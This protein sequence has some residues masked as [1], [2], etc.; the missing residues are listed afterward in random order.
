MNCRDLDR[1][2]ETRS[3]SSLTEAERCDGEA[4]ASTC[5]HCAPLWVA[6]ARVAAARVPAMPL[7]LAAR[8]RTLAT[9]HAQKS[10][11]RFVPRGMA[12]AAGG[13]V[14]L[15]AAAGVITAH[16]ASPPRPQL[17]EPVMAPQPVPEPIA[18]TQPAARPPE[19][20]EIDH[21]EP[22]VAEM[23]KSKSIAVAVVAMGAAVVE[24]QAPPPATESRMKT[25]EQIIATNDLNK[26]GIVTR[27]EAAQVN[28][29]LNVMFSAVYDLNH[30]GKLDVAEL[31]HA[32]NEV[33]V[34]TSLDK[35]TG[36]SGGSMAA[37][38]PETI[39]ANNDLNKDGV[40]TKDEAKTSGKALFRMWDSYDLNKDGQV[41]YAEL[42]KGQG[43]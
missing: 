14:V 10:V 43:Y 13:F 2:A 6:Y 7:E 25:A 32:M 36:Q 33:E 42:A 22:G 34:G 28:G 5:H 1:L 37:A 31:K 27:E 4:H 9:A 21:V 18:T 38:R 19:K 3:F 17:K 23:N 16:F 40:V 11:L 30:D 15:A 8:C 35:I 26:D 12:L 39:I 29:T 20:P 24:A 41:N